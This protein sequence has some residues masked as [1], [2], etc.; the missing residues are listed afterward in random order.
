M[1]P[2]QSIP[3]SAE[4]VRSRH[5]K[6]SDLLASPPIPFERPSKDSS[7]SDEDEDES[8]YVSFEAKVNPDDKSDDAQ[9]YKIK[10]LKFG[11]GDTTSEAYCEYRHHFDNLC[12]SLG[13]FEEA[14]RTERTEASANMRHNLLLATLSGK[15]HEYYTTIC[16]N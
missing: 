10:I 7:K 12:K 14:R 1:A 8:K 4:A 13:C 2:V 9:T 5:Q 16:N 15:A 11:E 3:L 6:E